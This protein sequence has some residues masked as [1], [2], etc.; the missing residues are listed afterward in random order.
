MR[1]DNK[2]LR[3]RNGSGLVLGLFALLILFALGLSLLSISMSSITTSKR[4]YLRARAL[5]VA[6]AG[7]ERGISFLRGTAPD[8]TTDGSWRTIHPSTE[9]NVHNGDTWY[10]ETLAD[11]ESFKICVRT[12][13]GGD[14]SKI[15]ITSVSTVTYGSASASRTLK[16]LVKRDEEN[17]SPW[18]NVIFG[19]VGQ[20]G[21][22]I[23]G[24]VVM[25]G[26][27]HLL[28]DG[29]VF[30]DID[31]DTNWDD[32]ESYIDSNSNGQYDVGES[33]TDTDGDGHRDA[34]EPFVDV[35]GNGA[36]DP[37]LTVTDLAQEVAGNANVGNSYDSTSASNVAMPAALRAKIPALTTESFGGETVES[38]LA[39]LRV[40][41]GRVNVSGSATVGDGNVTGNGIKETMNGSYVND[42]FGGN[43]GA[44]SVYAD[45]GNANGYDLGD[46]IV[47]FPALI[48]PYPPY[49]TYQDYLEANALVIS[50]DLSL[51]TESFSSSSALGSI[52][53]DATTNLLEISGIVYV[54]GNIVVGSN[55]TTI[56]YRG[57]GTLVSSN[58]IDVHANV[59]PETNFPITDKL[60]LIAAH[61]MGIATGSGDSQLMMALAMY[62]QYQI[63]I[64]KQCEIAGS[65]VSSYFGMTN[66]P[67]IY[68]VPALAQNLPPGMPGG[69]PIWIVTVSVLSWQ[70]AEGA[71]S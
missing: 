29:E 7:V 8:G 39:K 51:T 20:S 64:G 50:G 30:T 46:G 32:N 2:I 19:G 3:N 34:R 26:S 17:V 27:I 11:G 68:Q 21:R 47:S 44:G 55:D 22:S 40:K 10:E 63:T 66:V 5:Q 42:G 13:Y 48:D 45:N 67:H 4:D 58:D 70:D 23:N 15:F 18:N 25:R 9:A 36:R 14:T 54:N 31:G 53:Y 60:G 49:T 41:H 52:S 24:N 69:D 12:A 6:E 65:V 56:T 62:A 33:Y 57:S 35:N 61:N 59:L 71:G 38:L 1:V 37:A 28:G 43:A 16:V